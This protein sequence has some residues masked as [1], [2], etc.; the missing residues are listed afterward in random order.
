MFHS[1]GYLF[2]YSIN[3]KVCCGTWTLVLLKKWGGNDNGNLNVR[4]NLK[5]KTIINNPEPPTPAKTKT[6]KEK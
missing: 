6:E 5:G 1:M 3:Y 4:D 2:F